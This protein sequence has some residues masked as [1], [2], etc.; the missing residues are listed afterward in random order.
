MKYKWYL[1]E[2]LLATLVTHFGTPVSD[3]TSDNTFIQINLDL[4]KPSIDKS[5]GHLIAIVPLRKTL[6]K[7]LSSTWV[8]G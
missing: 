6:G 2:H 8:V 4:L 1:S 3:S 7:I 5:I